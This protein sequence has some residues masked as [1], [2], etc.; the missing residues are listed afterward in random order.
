MKQNHHVKR[1]IAMRENRK[2]GTVLEAAPFIIKIDSD[3]DLDKLTDD[4]KKSVQ[5]SL[6]ESMYTQRFG[7]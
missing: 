3:F 6:A 4:F 1:N 5:I 2:N 7:Q